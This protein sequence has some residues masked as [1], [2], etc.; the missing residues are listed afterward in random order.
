MEATAETASTDSTLYYKAVGSIAVY[1]TTVISALLVCIAR[2]RL[3]ASN[4][5]YVLI[6]IASLCTTW[7]YILSWFQKEYEALGSDLNRF[8]L[9]S[10]LFVQAYAIVTNTLPK[11]WWSSQLLLLTGT[12]LTCWSVEGQSLR[13][14]TQ[15]A[16]EA[17]SGSS[18]KK[19]W[20]PTWWFVLLGFFGSM[21][22]GGPL[23][24]AQLDPTPKKRAHVRSVPTILAW[25]ILFGEASV[26][27]TPFFESMSTRFTQN[28]I[29]THVLFLI[30]SLITF[31]PEIRQG[32]S[33]FS[34]PRLYFI[35]AMVGLV[36]HVMYS[37]PFAFSPIMKP[38]VLYRALWHN[39]CQT[40]I[41]ADM[42]FNNLLAAVYMIQSSRQLKKLRMGLMLTLVMPILSVSTVLPLYLGWRERQLVAR[43]TGKEKKKNK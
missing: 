15:A 39:H 19:K 25:L 42:M 13:V 29:L 14:E 26:M 8:I 38:V 30:P 11:W 4:A 36:S 23:F 35:L 28:L 37:L 17:S 34:L 22:V 3:S 7:Y 40:S 16:N 12:A 2:T 21:S 6:A 5:L 10:D 33:T 41:S 9:E 31:N 18:K 24:L 20:T 32:I 43:D 1:F 27:A